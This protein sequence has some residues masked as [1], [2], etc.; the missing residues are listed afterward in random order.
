MRIP[1]IW[2]LLL[3][4]FA[5]VSTP[6]LAGTF[7]VGVTIVGGASD[8]ASPFVT[9]TN[10]SD[11]GYQITQTDLAGAFSDHVLNRTGALIAAPAGGTYTAIGGTQVSSGNPNDGCD[12]QTFAMTGF[13]AGETFSYTF[14]PE[15][16][17]CANVVFDFSTRLV[18]NAVTVTV[19]FSGPGISGTQ[20]LTGH[21]WVKE[22][23]DPQLPSSG[24]NDLYRLTLS[25]TI[26]DTPEPAT[27]WLAGGAIV[28]AAL[29]AK[30]R[31]RASSGVR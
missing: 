18:A 2:P 26:A 28:L 13:D 10:L 5:A 9:F 19:K 12:P 25:D 20:T 29:R 17:A 4:A 11:A 21:T 7:S 8:F 16:N 3:T 30:S 23:I 15:N 6:L 14:D 31:L 1:N 24:S 22:L 27:F